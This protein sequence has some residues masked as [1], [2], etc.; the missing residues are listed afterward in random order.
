MKV[1]RDKKKVKVEERREL[2]KNPKYLRPINPLPSD[3][4]NLLINILT[5]Q[6]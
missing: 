6:Y 1:N 3:I 5:L 4:N 2:I